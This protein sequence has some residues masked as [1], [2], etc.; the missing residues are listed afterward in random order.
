MVNANRTLAGL[1]ALL[2]LAAT[3]L[4]DGAAAQERTYRRPPRGPVTHAPPQPQRTPLL[5]VVGL[6]EQRITVYDSTG[7]AMLDAPVSSGSTGYETPPGVFSVVQK[8]PDHHSNLYDDASMP[9]MQRL[10]WTGIALHAGA[11]PGYAA[12]HGCVRL[13]HDFAERLYGLTKT[14]MRVVVAREG[15]A[16][17]TIAE[18][19]FFRRPGVSARPGTEPALP[20]QLTPA[21]LEAQAATLARAAD[22]AAYRSNSER[23]AASRVRAAAQ[24]SER[25]V[26][27]A[28]AALARVEADLNA[29]QKLLGTGG[30]PKRLADAQK[31]TAEAPA[32]IDALRAQLEK[33]RTEVKAKLDA[34]S[35]S[36]RKAADAKTAHMQAVAAAEQAKQRLAPISV[37]VSRKSQRIYIRKAFHPVWEGPIVIRDADKPI[38]TFVFTALEPDK[39]TQE[40]R[41][42]VVSLYRNPTA[43]EPPTPRG[44]AGARAAAIELPTTN[45]AAAQAALDRLDVPAEMAD[46]ISET[47]LAGASLIISDEPASIETGKD[48]DF[49]VIMSGEPQGGIAIRQ[50]SRPERSDSDSLASDRGARRG[51]RPGGNGG[52]SFWFN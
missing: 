31:I 40:Q 50:N 32:R 49:V 42:N 12:S 16:P 36:E 22:E 25:A 41:W 9:F 15:I 13:P 17:V 37:F 38:G 47:I 34:A 45:A 3:V 39:T 14:G 35:E 52:F 44:K 21:A 48:T 19:A 27:Q 29:A 43:I 4:P 30:P 5:A 7:T 51:Q 11:L 23:A 33:V 1:A 26:R 6:R 8:E 20:T 24:P 10:T 28:E 2:T 46:R 18:P